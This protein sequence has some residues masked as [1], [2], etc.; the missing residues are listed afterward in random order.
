MISSTINP[1]SPNLEKC[2]TQ[3]QSLP[4]VDKVVI[5]DGYHMTI[6][7]ETSTFIVKN[8]SKP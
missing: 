1:L 8:V 6:V 7:D 3:M 5:G 2:R 4:K